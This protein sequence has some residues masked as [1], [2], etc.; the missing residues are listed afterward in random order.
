[1]AINLLSFFIINFLLQ[2]LAPKR[3]RF[4]I[5]SFLSFLCLY[6]INDQFLVLVLVLLL[7]NE[8]IKSYSRKRGREPH[9]LMPLFYCAILITINHLLK[10]PIV[11][12]SYVIL[13]ASLDLVSGYKDVWDKNRLKIS[14][15]NL[16]SFPKSS[17]GP[18]QDGEFHWAPGHEGDLK[19]QAAGKVFLGILKV[20]VLLPLFR[21][22]FPEPFMAK[23]TAVVNFFGFGLW[24][25]I[26]LYLEFSGVCD[27]VVAIFWSMGLNCK[28]NF[29]QPYFSISVTDFWKRWHMS[30][31]SWIRSHVYIP[32]G[33]NRK[34]TV[35]LYLNLFLAMV[36]CGA[37]HG[38]TLNFILWGAMQG[39]FMAFERAVGWNALWGRRPTWIPW[40]LTQVFVVAS[41]S[42][43][44]NWSL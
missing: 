35:R 8:G 20:F 19:K 25:Y 7:V 22:F 30:L 17:L 42:V 11:G 5:F 24:N 12:G 21:E 6:C 15:F 18:I 40:A 39:A 31:G 26:I 34:G 28:E 1:M 14:L 38:L 4:S 43:F 41:W 2:F 10:K 36:I 37:W 13:A 16:L 9:P 3:W 23:E 27:L 33:G 32:F 29:S 44:F